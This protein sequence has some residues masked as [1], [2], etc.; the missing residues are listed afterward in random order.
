[1]YCPFINSVFPDLP[2]VVHNNERILLAVYVEQFLFLSPPLP[3]VSGGTG[4]IE[5]TNLVCRRNEDC[6][7]STDTLGCTHSQDLVLQCSK[8]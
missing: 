6:T 5:A 4:R 2:S 7:F 8:F 1:M 3:R